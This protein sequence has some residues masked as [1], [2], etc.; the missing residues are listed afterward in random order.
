MEVLLSYLQLI[1]DCQFFGLKKWKKGEIKIFLS[2]ILSIFLFS[3]DATMYRIP[4]VFNL[5]AHD[6][7]KKPPSKV[8]YFSLNFRNFSTAKNGPVSLDS[9]KLTYIFQCFLYLVQLFGTQYTLRKKETFFHEKYRAIWHSTFTQKGPQTT[10][11]LILMFWY[12]HLW[13]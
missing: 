9:W 12:L 6:N 4:L 13:K 5:F 11:R 7:M 10:Q 1:E 2:F 8:A 3:A